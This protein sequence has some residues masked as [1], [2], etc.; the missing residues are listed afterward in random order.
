MLLKMQEIGFSQP[1][2]AQLALAVAGRLVHFVSNWRVLTSDTWVLEAI[3][4]F[5][6]PFSHQPN[7]L[8]YPIMHFPKDQMCLLREEANSLL[9]KG[10]IVKVPIGPKIGFYSTLFLVPKKEGS[11]HPVINLKRLNSWVSPQHFK[12]EGI[13]TLHD[14]LQQG[15]WLVKVDL[16][17][18]YFSMPIHMNH[19]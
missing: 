10:A 16:K 3:Q 2:V 9:G 8:N 12:M 15:D 18:A 13:P 19:Q 1:S 5:Q 17:D 4:G 14:L 7:Q 6:I 11:M